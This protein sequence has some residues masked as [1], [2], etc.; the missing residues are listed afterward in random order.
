MAA[1]DI[2]FQA[3]EDCADAARKA[4]EQLKYSAANADSSIFPKSIFG[5][6]GGSSS[7]LASVVSEVETMVGNEFGAARGKLDAVSRALDT[8]EQNVRTANR[9][10]G[11]AA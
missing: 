2:H 10:S 7:G 4:A 6:L 3:I 11:A 5:K 9:A 1:L 8:V